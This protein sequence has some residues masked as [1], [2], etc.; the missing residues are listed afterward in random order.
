MKEITY[1]DIDQIYLG[2]KGND[3]FKKV[4]PKTLV[5]NILDKFDIEECHKSAVENSVRHFNKLKDGFKASKKQPSESD[6]SRV[7]LEIPIPFCYLDL[8]LLMSMMMSQ[9]NM[10]KSLSIVSRC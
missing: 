8:L 4:T 6:I 10:M 2:I 1:C 9:L 5:D 7:L 3:R